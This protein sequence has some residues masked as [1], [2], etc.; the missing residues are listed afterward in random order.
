MYTSRLPVSLRF[1][2]ESEHV[3]GTYD[4]KYEILPL[5]L[6]RRLTKPVS[7]VAAWKMQEE[8]V[9]RGSFNL[10]TWF[11]E[12][13]IIPDIKKLNGGVYPVRVLRIAIRVGDRKSFWYLFNLCDIRSDTVDPAFRVRKWVLNPLIVA[14]RISWIRDYV[15]FYPKDVRCL[16]DETDHDKFMKKAMMLGDPNMIEFLVRSGVK[17]TIDSVNSMYHTLLS[18]TGKNNHGGGQFGYLRDILH[19]VI[20]K[21]RA[22]YPKLVSKRAVVEMMPF[23]EEL[24]DMND[25]DDV[26]DEN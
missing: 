24:D 23:Y 17:L 15:T 7:L 19:P 14:G 10:T 3:F 4:E 2:L 20:Q 16:F 8:V 13:Y 18:E 12:R 1:F 26:E 22:K 25:E 5:P 9:S 6:E 11:Y 21:L